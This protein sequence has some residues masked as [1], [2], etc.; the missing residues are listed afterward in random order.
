MQDQNWRA[1]FSAWSS[2]NAYV[3]PHSPDGGTGPGSS[4]TPGPGGLNA[5][6]AQV[7]H[8]DSP[9]ARIAF[10]RVDLYAIDLAERVDALYDAVIL[11]GNY[12]G[13]AI[14]DATGQ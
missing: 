5:W 1:R 10:W 11:A 7:P 13:Q 12:A 6:S 2:T 8:Q 9:H 3:D 4:T 14:Y